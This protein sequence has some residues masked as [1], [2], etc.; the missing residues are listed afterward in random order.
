M[1]R[2]FPLVEKEL[3]RLAHNYMRHLN[4]GNT[5][6]TTAIINETYLKLIDHEKVKWQSRAHFFAVAAT[7]MRR[8]LQ[9]YVRDRKALRRG[10]ALTQVEMNEA[11]M[12]TK[13]K[14]AVI[15]ENRS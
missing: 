6:Q 9:N 8:F 4:Q 13:Q 5:L 10:G 11:L 15:S 14:S 2:L 3:H 12:F 7:V 1:E